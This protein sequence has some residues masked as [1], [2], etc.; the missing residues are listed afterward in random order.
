MKLN[1]DDLIEQGLVRKKTY[2]EGVYK[3]LSVLKYTKKVFFKN[4]WHL[5]ERLLECRGTVV[6]EE[7]NVIVLPFKKVFNLGEN[8]TT[9][10]PERKVLC[11]IKVNG[12]ML[13]VTRTDDYGLIVS[14]TGTLDSSFAELGKNWV[15]TL[16]KD[17]ITE[18]ITFLFEVCDNTD[19][20]IVDEDEGIYLIGMRHLDD[21]KMAD[22]FY[23]DGYSTV[24]KSKRLSKVLCFFK[25]LDLNVKHEGFMIRDYFTGEV[26]AKYKSSYYLVKKALMRM[27]CKRTSM[28][29]NNPDEFKKQIDEEYYELH[30]FIIAKYSMEE[31]IDF[32]QEERRTIFEGYFK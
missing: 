28:M 23:L 24:L 6:D 13:A 19:K 17:A 29:F 2:T 25:D 5:D 27:G 20:H 16:E 22:E 18:G 12:F 26:L 3:G 10:D 8:G 31:Y 7:D 15:D 1:V 9:V 32:T 11:P 30:K 4:L 14:T 21:G